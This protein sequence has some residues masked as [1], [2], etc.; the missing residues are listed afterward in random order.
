[1]LL[2]RLLVLLVLLFD[3]LV[4]SRGLLV[5]LLRLMWALR[6]MRGGVL[7][8]SAWCLGVGGVLSS[9]GLV[10]ALMIGSTSA[11]TA[12]TDGDKHSW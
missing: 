10:R 11:I 5:L 12:A 7:G 8:M 6:I 1:V 2:L 3:G 4:L 9:T